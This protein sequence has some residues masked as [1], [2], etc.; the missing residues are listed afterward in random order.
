VG[1]DRIPLCAD[2][3]TAEALHIRQGQALGILPI[4]A[5]LENAARRPR[6]GSINRCPGRRSA[7]TGSLLGQDNEG[8]F[9]QR[10]GRSSPAA[11]RSGGAM[12]SVLSR[13]GRRSPGFA[14]MVC[15]GKRSLLSDQSEQIQGIRSL[16]YTWDYGW[17]RLRRTVERRCWRTPRRSRPNGR[18][19]SQ[20]MRDRGS[21]PK[22]R[23]RTKD[24]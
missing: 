21:V 4:A 18:P 14:F 5:R 3:R 1:S 20:G 7:P 24:Q 10:P 17:S 13:S 23:G 16:P 19:F 6:H 22:C 2:T 9:A 8:R 11:I 12:P 15:F